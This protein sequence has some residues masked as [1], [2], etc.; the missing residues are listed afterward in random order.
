MLPI[1]TQ[2][3]YML[4]TVG[5]GAAAGFLYDVYFFLFRGR[6][7]RGCWRWVWDFIFC[8]VLFLLF[9]YYLIRL[10]WGDF[11]LWIA[12]ALA[13]GLLLYNRLVRSN[14]K[15]LAFRRKIA[16]LPKKLANKKLKL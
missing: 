14:K 5:V 6:K 2:L 4:L 16:G 12:L 13:A 3:L 9:V 11:R 1:K 10:V 8:L 7:L 15:F